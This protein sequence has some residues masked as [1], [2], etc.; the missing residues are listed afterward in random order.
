M[1]VSAPFMVFTVVDVI[2]SKMGESVSVMVV[3]SIVTV[4]LPTPMLVSD[5]YVEVKGIT[6]VVTAEGGT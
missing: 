5:K 6:V 3:L 1:I 2:V 4:S